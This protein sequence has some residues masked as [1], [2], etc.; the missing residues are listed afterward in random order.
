MSSPSVKPRIQS[1][2]A[3]LHCFMNDSH[4]LVMSRRSHHSQ[5]IFGLLR[6]F[7]SARNRTRSNGLPAASR[8]CG[9]RRVAAGMVILEVPKIMSGIIEEI[10]LA[11]SSSECQHSDRRWFFLRCIR[12][13]EGQENRIQPKSNQPALRNL[14]PSTAVVVVPFKVVI[15]GLDGYYTREDGQKLNNEERAEEEEDRCFLGG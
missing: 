3:L 9:V 14:R 6:L 8:A 12:P 5:P 15:S 7:S 4:P 2:R 11:S 10:D 13:S 1:F